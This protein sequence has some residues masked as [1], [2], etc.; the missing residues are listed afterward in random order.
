MPVFSKYGIGV[1]FGGTRVSMAAS[2]A[3]SGSAAEISRSIHQSPDG[4]ARGTS[5][6]PYQADCTQSMLPA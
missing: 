2:G 3:A 1:S 5:L 6:L 4:K